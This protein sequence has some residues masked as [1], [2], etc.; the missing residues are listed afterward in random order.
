[1]LNVEVKNRTTS[2]TNLKN[3]MEPF[4]SAAASIV[5]KSAATAAQI[6]IS[7]HLSKALEQD[8]T[9]QKTAEAVLQTAFEAWFDTLLTNLRWEYEEAEVQSMWLDSQYATESFLQDEKVSAELLAPLS[10]QGGAP[11]SRIL[12]ERWNAL[13]PQP[14]PEKFDLGMVLGL[15]QKRLNKIRAAHPKLR[16]MLFSESDI[17]FLDHHDSSSITQL[18]IKGYKTI[19]CLDKFP[20]RAVNIL[21]GANG[22]GKS[23]FISFFSL[24]REL[25]EQ[26]FQ[27]AIREKGGANMNMFMGTKETHELFC[28]LRFGMKGVEFCLNITEDDSLFINEERI[29]FGDDFAEKSRIISHGQRESLVKEQAGSKLQY[30]GSFINRIYKTMS[31][32]AVYHFHDTGKTCPM[33]RRGSAGDNKR[34]R[35]DAGNLAAFLLKL[36][37]D[38]IRRYDEIR[39][40]VQLVAPFFDDFKLKQDKTD[41]GEMVELG[42]CQKN[43]DYIFHPCQLSDGLLRFIALSTVLL[44]PDPPSV[45]LLDEPELGLHP[46][47]LAI[48]AGLISQASGN[49]QLI[50]ST[51]SPDL[52]NSFEP[53][54]IIVVERKH[55]AS[56]FKRLSTKDLEI[57][58]DEYD[59]LGTLWQKN[60]YGGGP[61]YE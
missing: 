11:D 17:L 16:E 40:T 26:R 59:T 35:S 45:I 3:T 52:L 42:W 28:Q 41:I 13:A 43:S 2:S 47:A 8:K 34:L 22:S 58:L 29:L 31:S 61:V 9:Q 50:I 20:L 36:R 19:D 49:A 15:Y 32:W 12:L 48:V 30:S 21:V 38:D 4:F 56:Q 33:R 24:L 57:W 37:N 44:Q 23:N 53:E 46:Y 5:A 14:L 18:T 39:D 51:Q 7:K 6:H 54:D 55:G 60:I 27:N 25:I 10:E 1:M